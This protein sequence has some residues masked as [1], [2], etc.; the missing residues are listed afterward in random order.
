MLPPPLQVLASRRAD[1]F[2]GVNTREDRCHQDVEL[3]ILDHSQT[4]AAGGSLGP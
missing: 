1:G 4:G 2:E 3:H